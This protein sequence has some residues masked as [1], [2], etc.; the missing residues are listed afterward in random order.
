MIQVACAVFRHVR[1]AF[2][3]VFAESRQESE[4][5]AADGA[6]AAGSRRLLKGP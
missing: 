5:R 2:D 6:D 1:G 3:A 4:E